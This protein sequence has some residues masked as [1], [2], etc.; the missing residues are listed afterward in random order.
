M[1]EPNNWPKLHNAMWPGVV[2]KGGDAEPPIDLK[3][4]LDLTAKAEVDGAKFDGVD[5]FLAEPHTSI[6][7]ADD[8][9]KSL[10]IRS[11]R[12]GWSSARLWRRCGRRSAAAR[13]WAARRSAS[14]SSRWSRRRAASARSCAILASGPMASCVSIRRPACTIGPK[15]PAAQHEAD[16]RDLP[17][18]L[19]RRRSAR[20][21]ARRR[22]RN[23]LGR[24]AR[25]EEHGRF[26]GN[27]RASEDARFSGRYGAHASLYARLQRSGRA[28]L[29]R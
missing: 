14:V 4:L 10:L 18:G 23:L 17:R 6:D 21:A 3:T 11:V 7:S 12:A 1:T 27:R 22:G 20:R 5:L 25:L 15:N 16:R 8:Q 19:R 2:G 26:A 28:H 24:H 29:A 13:R 9:I